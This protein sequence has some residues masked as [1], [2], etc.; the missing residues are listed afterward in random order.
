M[1]RVVQVTC[2]VSICTL[3]SHPDR[4]EGSWVIAKQVKFISNGGISQKK[5][6]GEG[7]RSKEKAGRRKEGKAEEEFSTYCTVLI[8]RQYTKYIH[9]ILT[10]LSKVGSISILLY[11]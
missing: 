2:S 7:K 8:Y 5:G 10:T 1:R 9:L 4:K 6:E 3:I 11:T